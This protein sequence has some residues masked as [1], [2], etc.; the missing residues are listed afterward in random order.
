IMESLIPKFS[1]K[2]NLIYIDPPYATGGNFESKTFIG[3]NNAF[4]NKRAYSDIWDGGIDEYIDFL[5]ERLLLMRNLLSDKGSIYVHL[6]W[7]VSHYIKVIMDE[8]FGKENFQNSLIWAYPAASAKTRRFFIRS[9]DTIL[10]YTKS[11]YYTFNDDPNIYMEYSDRVKF[12][13]KKDDKGTY[14]HRGGSH[15]GKKLSQKVYTSNKGIF[16]RDVWTDLPYIRANTTE[17]QAFSTQKPERLLKRI[18]LASSNKDDIVADFFCGTGTTLV[19]AEKLGRRWIGSDIGKHAINISRKRILD[20]WNSNDL[21][22]WGQKYQEIPH[23][24]KILRINNGKQE[25]DIDKRFLIDN[26]QIKIINTPFQKV[27]FEIKISKDKKHVFI[28]LVGYSVP[29]LNS[30]N[31]KLKAKIETFSDWI[32]S[33]AIDFN[34]QN[35]YFCTTWISYRTIKNRSLNLT[36]ISYTYNKQGKYSI[37]V[38]VNDILGNETIQEY[39]INI[40]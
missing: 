19:V 13:L 6:D 35:D 18:I 14:Y 20:V 1:N 26:L 7:H 4:E 5:Y 32:D 10:F 27:K 22:K 38:K 21:L 2:I 30:I 12:A 28:E 25:F 24:F 16:P 11:D 39:E 33:W 23:P 31:E 17:Y 29:D 40:D 9:F 37:A 3:E 34:Q 15:N 36:S 8:I